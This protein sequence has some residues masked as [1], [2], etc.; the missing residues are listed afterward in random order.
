MIGKCNPRPALRAQIRIAGEGRIG[1]IV[2]GLLLRV[3]PVAP[4]RLVAR[5]SA[6]GTRAR[7]REAEVPI[8]RSGIG[9][10]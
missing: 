4:D 9:T 5:V 3:E 7:G 6:I 2:P 1:Q 8:R 10:Q